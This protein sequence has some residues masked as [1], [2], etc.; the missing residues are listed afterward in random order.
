MSPDPL[1]ERYLSQLTAALHA[2]GVAPEEQAGIRADI[3]SH[4]A[5]STS[6]GGRLADVLERLGPA[7]RLARAYRAESLLR[8]A[9]GRHGQPLRAWTGRLVGG[10]T[11][12]AAALLALLLGA[13]GGALTLAGAMAALV[14]TVAPW[15]PIDPTLRAGWPQVVVVLL[16]I[17][18]AAAGVAVLRLA[19]WNFVLLRE[20]LRDLPNP[21]GETP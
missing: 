1:V 9:W 17:A 18:V 11:A 19:R 20:R 3:E 2:C 10:A 12:A 7:D 6:R 16:S 15:L 14:G 4:V 13:V 8:P 21:K 5:E